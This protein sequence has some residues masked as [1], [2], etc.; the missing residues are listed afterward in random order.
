VEKSKRIVA[1]SAPGLDAPFRFVLPCFASASSSI[2]APRIAFPDLG[3]SRPFQP[4]CWK[5]AKLAQKLG[6]LQP[7]IA[8]LSHECMGQLAY[9]G[10]PNT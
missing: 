10:Q 8:V 2:R 6:Q 7:S 1:G 9:L 5:D 3:E 4:G